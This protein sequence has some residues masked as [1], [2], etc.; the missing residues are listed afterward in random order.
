MF[1]SIILGLFACSPK[2]I[3]RSDVTV[4]TEDYK[5]IY[6]LK[7]DVGEVIYGVWISD[8]LPYG[9]KTKPHLVAP[10]NFKK[11][12]ERSVPHPDYSNLISSQR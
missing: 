8:S 6:I 12:V 11:L 10:S 9:D 1:L 2:L 5:H 7:N 4:V 3:Q